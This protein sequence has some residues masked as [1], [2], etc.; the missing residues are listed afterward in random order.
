MNRAK[1]R[2]RRDRQRA[3][4]FQYFAVLGHLDNT[5]ILQVLDRAPYLRVG[6]EVAIPLLVEQ[7]NGG[8][9]FL[10]RK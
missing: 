1:D 10:F 4:T 2:R 9:A 8:S 7:P 5:T 6:G 3:G